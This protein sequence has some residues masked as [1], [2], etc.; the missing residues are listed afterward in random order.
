MLWRELEREW[1]SELMVET[2]GLMIG[3]PAGT[4][5]R[6]AI[7]SAEV[8]GLEHKVFPAREVAKRF[9]AIR[10]AESMVAVWEPRAGM[11]FPERCIWAHLSG[12]AA[13][14]GELRFQEPAVRW[15]ADGEGVRVWSSKGNYSA[16]RVI[17]ATGGWIGAM[18]PELSL[19]VTVERQVLFWFAPRRNDRI[20]RAGFCPV[21]IWEHRPGRYFYGFPA[22]GDGVKF[23]IHHEGE[24]CAPDLVNRHVSQDEVQGMRDLIRP[25][26]P[27]ANGELRSTAVCFY[28]NLPDG[29]FLI[30]VHPDHPQVLLASP[31]SG[32]G[33]KFSSVVG[34]VLADIATGGVPRFD[35]S[36]FRFRFR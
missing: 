15:E 14:G 7:R 27:D 12:A 9:L 28:T 20:F 17:L 22:H 5:V 21:H 11:L 26:V 36:L 24:S 18:V 31:C 10:P 25:L 19:P 34:E 13:H 4:L 3:P 32:H 23:A 33:F 29:H 30:D 8:H 6:G 35:L 1:R 2:G 16:D